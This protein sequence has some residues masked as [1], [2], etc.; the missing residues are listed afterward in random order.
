MEK[1]DICGWGSL[2]PA[3]YIAED[4]IPR[5]GGLWPEYAHTMKICV[6][7]FEENLASGML[8]NCYF[9]EH[10]PFHSLDQ[11]LFAL[12]SVMNQT[13]QPQSDTE[14]RRE[15][16]ERPQRKRQKEKSEPAQA[17]EK[18]SPFYSLNEMKESR[19]RLANFLIR[20]Y[21][22]QHSSMQ[23]VLVWLETNQQCSFRSELELLLLLKNAL[24]RAQEQKNLRQRA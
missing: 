2:Q 17:P 9:E 8:C 22:R 18:M 4:D 10:L 19:G 23:G 15:L 20:V 1:Q 21:A 13:K 24:S 11:M 16:T 7:S 12:E 3:G 5:G 6:D 14:L